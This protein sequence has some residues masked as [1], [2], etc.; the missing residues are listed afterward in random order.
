MITPKSSPVAEYCSSG[1]YK[2]KANPSQEVNEASL[3]MFVSLKA[4]RGLLRAEVP[5]R[6][7]CF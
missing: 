7:R 5:R 2:P 4:Q 6:E 1:Y 3:I